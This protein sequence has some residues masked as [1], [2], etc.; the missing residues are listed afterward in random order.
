MI[1]KISTCKECYR[2]VDGM[3]RPCPKYRIYV[4]LTRQQKIEYE[5]DDYDE[6]QKEAKELLKRYANLI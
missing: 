6:M 3:Y 1:T 2:L 5:K 4:I